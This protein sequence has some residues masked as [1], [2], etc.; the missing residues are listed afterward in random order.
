MVHY[1]WILCVALGVGSG[2]F[3][4]CSFDQGGIAG[5][6]ARD[7]GTSGRPDAA[8]R[9]D[10]DARPAVTDARTLADAI[11]SPPPDARCPGDVLTVGFSNI[12][13]C[14][15]P[16]P[17]PPQTLA[18]PSR[19]VFD[20]DTG[21][22]GNGSST[23]VVDSA[24]IAQ[25]TGGP[26]VRILAFEQLTIWNNLWVRGS[27]PLVLVSYGD[28]TL[29]AHFL[30]AATSDESG[31]GGGLA[32]V[33]GDGTAAEDE[34]GR[35]GVIQG[36]NGDGNGGSGGGGGGYGTSGG[37][38]GLVGGASAAAPA[39]GSV[40]GNAT[41]V[42][43]RGGCSGGGGANQGGP[44]GGGGGALQLI[45]EGTISIEAALSARGGGGSAPRP[46]DNQP[47]AAGGGGGGAGGALLIEAGA[48]V[49][50][51]SGRVTANGGGGGEGTR[52]GGADF[53]GAD[54]GDGFSQNRTAAPG[55]SSDT[56]SGGDGG[57]GAWV[58]GSAGPGGEGNSFDGL[59]A[60]GGGG[61][62]GVGRIRFNSSSISVDPAA[63]VSPPAS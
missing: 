2:S 20:T 37:S 18:G 39:G 13:R 15:I 1:R 48:I 35:P 59:A 41:I 51:D 61:G 57:D 12:A 24:V 36:S 7:G 46:S 3:V 9:F 5:A 14:D 60:G 25:I 34:V 22:L 40:G 44:G 26:N 58:S 16:A 52:S 53:G 11:T 8:S 32:A 55:G 38:G 6:G 10:P 27:L 50:T 21:I 47:S 45:V 30:V 54:G 63:Y 49:V 29:G 17:N 62:G 56:S 4:G 23:R 42:P 33:C 19:W 28:V 43:L 31:P